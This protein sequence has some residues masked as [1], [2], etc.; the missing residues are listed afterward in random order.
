[1]QLLR[2]NYFLLIS[3]L[4]QLSVVYSARLVV[5]VSGRTLRRSWTLCTLTNGPGNLTAIIKAM[6]MYINKSRINKGSV[7][8]QTLA[9]A[10][11]ANILYSAFV[12]VLPR[13]AEVFFST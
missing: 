2:C 13:P 3:V 4:F 1:M 9:Y 12:A 11:S 7:L 5:R 10:I 6:V 8:F